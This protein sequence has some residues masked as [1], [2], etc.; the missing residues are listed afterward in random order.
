MPSNIDFPAEGE[1]APFYAPYVSRVQGD[2][3]A[4]LRKNMDEVL[5]LL[6]SMPEEKGTFRYAP[7]KWSVKDVINHIIDA[8]RVYTYRALRIARGDTTELPG[9]DENAFVENAGANKRSFADLAEEFKLVREAT[10]ALY[11]S[12]D[13]SVLANRGKANNFDFTVRG[14]I[15]ISAGHPAHHLNILRERYGVVKT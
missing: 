2:P 14:I 5:A 3:L 6:R 11:K 1:F 12:F 15:Y 10:I 8:E 13:E 9:F 4:S 7:E